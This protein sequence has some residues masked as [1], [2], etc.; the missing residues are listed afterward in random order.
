MSRKTLLK[1]QDRLSRRRKRV[2]STII[3]TAERPRVSVYRSL[4]H[5]YIQL[6]DDSKGE[7]LVSGSTHELKSATKAAPAKAT[8]ENGAKKAISTTGK[9][10]KSKQIGLLVAEKAKQ[11]KIKDVVFD[12]GGR[13]YHGRIK[14]VAEGLREG[15]LK[16]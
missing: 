16:F 7:T 5:I 1:K 14:S 8:E 2:R 6:I 9:V 12:R 11:K 4:N 10:V 15:G 13:L 3:G